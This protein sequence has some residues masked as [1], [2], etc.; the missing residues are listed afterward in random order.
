MKATSRDIDRR[1]AWPGE[2][3]NSSATKVRFSGGEFGRISELMR[4][5]A[6]SGQDTEREQR[7]GTQKTPAGDRYYVKHGRELRAMSLKQGASQRVM[8]FSSRL[9][10]W[11][12]GRKLPDIS[13]FVL[14]IDTEEIF[15]LTDTPIGIGDRVS[16][17]FDLPFNNAYLGGFEAEVTGTGRSNFPSGMFAVFADCPAE[18]IQRLEDFLELKGLNIDIVA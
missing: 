15:I 1:G 3:R 7:S 16:I 10:V 9:S 6:A 8:P 14:N 12:E 5:F 18:K 4:G 13:D 11:Q 17:G 2:H